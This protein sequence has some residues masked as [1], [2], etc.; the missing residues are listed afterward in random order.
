MVEYIWAWGSFVG[1]SITDLI[2]LI[3]IILV[4][5]SISLFISF[6]KFFLVIWIFYLIFQIYWHTVVQNIFLWGFNVHLIYC[7]VSFQFQILVV[8]VASIYFMNNLVQGFINI[9]FEEKN[10][11]LA[12][13]VISIILFFPLSVISYLYFFF[14]LS[15]G[16]I[17]CFLSN[18]L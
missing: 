1:I 4:W 8:C 12:F 5:F 11:F 7:D 9:F 6:W 2:S 16:F 14:L 13:L 18:F 17:C 3:T 10:Q 15:L